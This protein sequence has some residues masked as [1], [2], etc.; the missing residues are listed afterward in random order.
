MQKKLF[1]SAIAVLPALLAC[2]HKHHTHQEEITNKQ[3]LAGDH[4]IHSQYSMRWD[5]STTP[6]TPILG[7]DARYTAIENA[8]K[9][10]QYGLDWMVITDHGGPDHS[11]INKEQAYPDLLDSRQAVPEVIQFYGMEF[12]TPGARHSSLIVPHSHNEAEHLYQIEKQ[13]NRRE[14]YPDQPERDT[15]ELM[16]Q[17]L[18]AMQQQSPQPLVFANH[19]GRTATELG[20]YTK[21]TPQELRAWNDTAPQVAIGMEGA[22]GHQANALLFN[23]EIKKTGIRG[24][25]KQHPTMGGFD[26]MT[27]ELGGF[28]DSMLAEGRK[29]WITANSDSH[30]HYTEGGTDFWPGEYSKTYVYAEK[31]YQSIIDNL[32]AGR[33]FVTTGDLINQLEFSVAA[34]QHSVSI[35]QTL[36]IHQGENISIKIRVR[37]PSSNNANAE[38]PQVTRIDL[39]K[40]N[41]TGRNQDANN[42]H[43]PSTQVIKRFTTSD[44]QQ[45]GEWLTMLY[46]ITNIQQSFYLRLRGTNQADE[47]EPQIDPKGENPWADL[48][49]YANPVFVEVGH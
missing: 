49:F 24:G 40:G 26:Q 41:I 35:G 9:A 48:W 15:E 21:V 7:G 36:H 47:L 4:H 14:I 22:P 12:D 5:H 42:H 46:Q 25:Y 16:L 13:F 19:P 20:V 1:I 11:K 6:A 34:K 43:N 3:W 27:A 23:G 8:Q 44:W 30:V 39:I 33:I 29:W 38:N 31:N 45:S 32:R 17:A 18:K 10:K 37:D 2:Q 28:W